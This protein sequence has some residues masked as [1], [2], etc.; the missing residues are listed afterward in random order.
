M[1]LLWLIL[2]GEGGARTRR[3]VSQDNASHAYVGLKRTRFSKPPSKMNFFFFQPP[4]RRED[5]MKIF[6]KAFAWWCHSPGHGSPKEE[7]LCAWQF[8]W[9]CLMRMAAGT[10]RRRMMCLD[11]TGTEQSLL[12]QVCTS[13]WPQHH[14]KKAADGWRKWQEKSQQVSVQVCAHWYVCVFQCVFVWMW[15]LMCVHIQTQSNFWFSVVCLPMN[16][17]FHSTLGC[18]V[19]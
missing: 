2:S 11:Q 13:L 3:Q 8:S 9:T 14:P 15:T 17:C 19:T 1:G 5:N 18:G 6:F 12:W 4:E 7:L 10:G 16:G